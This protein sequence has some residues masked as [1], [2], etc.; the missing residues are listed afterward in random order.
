VSLSL[1]KLPP[2]LRL[3]ATVLGLAIIVAGSIWSI[4]G[5]GITWSDMRPGP[6][7]LNLLVVQP[8]ILA[9]A[10]VTLSL[11]ARAIGSTVGFRG[12]LTTVAYATLAEVLPLPGGALVRGAALM[13]SGATLRDATS[14]V[15]VTA[16]MS[17]ALLVSLSA[18][19][20]AMLGTTQAWIVVAP[21]LAALVIS[22]EF[23]RRRAGL[24]LTLAMLAIRIVTAVAGA[25]SVYLA[26][27]AL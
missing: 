26:L 3:P 20:L 5:L 25:G 21:S 11:S 16:V 6:L 12:G 13:K 24:R 9:I 4:S 1:P 15:T 10:S 7:L 14:I 17:L 8:L 27:A 19:A 18:A 23:V 2:K 22:L